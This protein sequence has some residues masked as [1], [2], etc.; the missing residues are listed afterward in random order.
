MASLTSEA[1]YPIYASL[2]VCIQKCLSV[3]FYSV[4]VFLM[5]IQPRDSGVVVE[6][7]RGGGGSRQSVQTNR[8]FDQICT[9]I[10]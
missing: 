4:Q 9:L 7:E 6:R 5:C 3:C 2:P 1:H 8:P 10:T